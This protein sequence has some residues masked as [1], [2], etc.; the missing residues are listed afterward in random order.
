MRRHPL[1]VEV[2]TFLTRHLTIDRKL[3]RSTVLSYRDTLK[4]FLNHCQDGKK[5]K[6]HFDIGLINYD[7]ILKFLARIENARQCAVS[8]RN[9]RLAA[10]K[11]FAKFLLL[12][13]PE[14]SATIS[15]VMSLSFKKT[16]RKLKNYL[17]EQEI[18]VFLS[19]CEGPKWV[20]RRN[21]LMFDF[22]IQTG[23]RV[24]E[25][26]SVKPEDLCLSH[27]PFVKIRGKGRKERAIPLRRIFHV[28][29]IQ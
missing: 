15:R 9:Q 18:K 16:S 11:S 21:A 1:L 19:C 2:E 5:G 6:F 8:T 7:T 10:M 28:M 12:R 3:A 22:M 24:S 27:D 26:I 4:L 13:H 23:V 25:L 29:E 20:Q 14:S 17:D